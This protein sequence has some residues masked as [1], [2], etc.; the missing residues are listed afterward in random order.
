MSPYRPP[1]VTH[2][3]CLPRARQANLLYVEV[4][5]RHKGRRCFSDCDACRRPDRCPFRRAA[6][7]ARPVSK[8][9]SSQTTPC[10]VPEKEGSPRCYWKH[11]TGS[12]SSCCSVSDDR[13]CGRLQ[14]DVDGHDDAAAARGPLPFKLIF[15][16][17]IAGS[18]VP[19]TLLA[20]A[21]AALSVPY[22]KF[23]ELGELSASLCRHNIQMKCHIRK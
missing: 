4:R 3:H 2:A 20:L 1:W 7:S 21:S 15:C 9:S 18:T 19:P 10:Y 6:T 22:R 23:G 14:P 12:A 16:V 8:G 17:L 5:E 13:P 11:S